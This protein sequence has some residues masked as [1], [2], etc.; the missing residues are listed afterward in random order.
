MNV[1][2]AR[3]SQKS[4]SQRRFRADDCTVTRCNKSWMA[5]SE[6]QSIEAVFPM[7]ETVAT[8]RQRSP[9]VHLSRQP[10]LPV[11]RQVQCHTFI[12]SMQRWVVHFP[13]LKEW[14]WRIVGSTR[15]DHGF[16]TRL[17]SKFRQQEKKLAWP[18]A[19]AQTSILLDERHPA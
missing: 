4:C 7:L 2:I 10:R 12:P 1:D 13:G 18:P 11:D 9:P 8:Y 3:A 16:S 14:F 15:I 19:S 6:K 17:S 5:G